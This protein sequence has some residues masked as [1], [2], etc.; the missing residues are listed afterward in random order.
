[1]ALSPLFIY[2]VNMTDAN[3]NTAKTL[4]QSYQNQAAITAFQVLLDSAPENAEHHIDI[5]DIH[6]L[7]GNLDQAMTHYQYALDLA[8]NPEQ[9]TLLTAAYKGAGLTYLVR[10]E[11]NSAELF[12]EKAEQLAME[13]NNDNEAF[14][15]KAYRSHILFALGRTIPAL[16]LLENEL[17]KTK[18]NTT[19]E[20]EIELRISLGMIKTSVGQ[21]EQGWQLY[22]TGLHL[23]RHHN[24]LRLESRALFGMGN[25]R[26]AQGLY[27]PA[28]ALFEQALGL[29]RKIGDIRIDIAISGS[30]G[31][32]LLALGKFH[33]TLDYIKPALNRAQK[34]GNLPLNKR[35][36]AWLA[37]TPCFRQVDK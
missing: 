35:S 33:D 24:L 34:S 4:K 11:F 3:V 6:L 16:N 9:K 36:N 28:H 18:N 29:A 26:M 32:C 27:H 2:P 7:I 17:T 8:A 14:C 23:A 20:G 37:L 22:E 10:G 25:T 19:P 5:A 31:R 15:C 30:I 21:I 12:L 1:M 13:T